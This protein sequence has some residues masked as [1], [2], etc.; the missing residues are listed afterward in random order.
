[1]KHPVRVTVACLS[2]AVAAALWLWNVREVGQE[3]RQTHEPVT[4]PVPAPI[5]YEVPEA[6]KDLI[7][8][9]RKA[10]QQ[11]LLY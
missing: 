10:K 6:L 5:N 7:D 9:E 2:L 4:M 11:M 3:W 8:A 1:M